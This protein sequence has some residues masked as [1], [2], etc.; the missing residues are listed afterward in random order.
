MLGK[1]CKKVRLK[2][3]DTSLMNLAKKIRLSLMILALQIGDVK[4]SPHTVGAVE[5]TE[6]R[7]TKISIDS[8]HIDIETGEQQS[9]IIEKINFDEKKCFIKTSMNKQDLVIIVNKTEPT[10]NVQ[11]QVNMKLVV[12]NPKTKHTISLGSGNINMTRLEGTISANLGAGDIN[13]TH[14]KGMVRM[15]LGSGNVTG[16]FAPHPNNAK[17]QTVSLTQGTGS[18]AFSFHEDAKLSWKVRGVPF[19]SIKSEFES[20]LDKPDFCVVVTSG[21][22]TGSFLKTKE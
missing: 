3:G 12:T 18:F 5:N 10:D 1:V 6:I 8:G 2:K 11:C 14:V 20:M 13:L 17:Q 22:A 7:L 21:S 4:A 15:N 19:H 16:K 9:L